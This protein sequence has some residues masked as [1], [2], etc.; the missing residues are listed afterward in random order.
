MS[1][2]QAS[3]SSGK[4]VDINLKNAAKRVDLTTANA[5]KRRAVEKKKQIK[6]AKKFYEK[7]CHRILAQHLKIMQSIEDSEDDSSN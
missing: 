6:A 4:R 7:E 5:E 3:G 2:S 1:S